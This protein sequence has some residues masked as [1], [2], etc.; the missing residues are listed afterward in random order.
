MFNPAFNHKPVS[1]IVLASAC[2]CL[3][4]AERSASA[5]R[6]LPRSFTSLNDSAYSSLESS[7]GPDEWYDA[8]LT[9]PNGAMSLNCAHVTVLGNT[10]A[11]PPPGLEAGI[12]VPSIARADT[13]AAPTERPH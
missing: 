5:L 3:M 6:T 2:Q 13:T 11:P 10:P 1:R 7:G 4:I 8:T 12:C 9:T